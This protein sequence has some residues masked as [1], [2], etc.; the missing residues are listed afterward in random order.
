MKILISRRTI[1]LA[2][3][4]SISVTSAFAQIIN[5]GFENPAV[6]VGGATGFP[7]GSTALTGWTVTGTHV[8][9][10]HT[11]YAESF[12][13]TFNSFA[14]AQALDIT[15]AGNFGPTCS[16]S[17]S[18]ATTIGQEYKVSFEVGR[19]MGN[20]NDTRYQTPSTIDLYIDGALASNNT[21]SN[22]G[23]LGTVDWKHFDVTFTA[24]T[25][26]TNILFRNATPDIISGGNNYAG[27][28][29]VSMTTVPEPASLLFL[30]AGVSA[31]LRKKKNHI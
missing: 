15:G 4:L 8:G 7:A 27:L 10:L 29:G 11:N 23:T 3:V 2:A 9:V 25:S 6:P 13:I 28:D 24:T 5:G 22:L 18:V 30:G 31:L 21:N 16:V 14:G 19:A 26:L 1:A 17:Q 20:P 12:Q